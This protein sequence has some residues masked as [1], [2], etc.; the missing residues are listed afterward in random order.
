[1]HTQLNEMISPKLNILLADDDIDDCLFFK[2]ALEELD[3][4]TQLSTVHDGEQL[5]Q[6][7]TAKTNEPPHVL[8]LDLNMPRKNG[9][10]CLDEIKHSKRLRALPVI[11]FSTSYDEHIADQLYQQGA[12]YYICKPTNFSQLKKVIL[13]ALTLAVQLDDAFVIMSDVEGH[14]KQPPKEKFLLNHI[15]SVLL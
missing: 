8:F 15:K 5:M 9:V 7:L 6:H 14:S 13:K 1:M 2:E 10:A 11:I 12:H 4:P 3:L